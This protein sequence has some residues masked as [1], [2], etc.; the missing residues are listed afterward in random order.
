MAK[1]TTKIAFDMRP[2]GNMN[3]HG[4]LKGR[5]ARFDAHQ[6]RLE[7]KKGHERDTFNGSFQANPSKK[8]V[9]GSAKTWTHS[10]KGHLQ[11]QITNASISAAAVVAA[12]KSKTNKD[13]RLV[14]EKTFAGNDSIMGSRQADKLYGYDGNDTINGG[15]GLAVDKIDGGKGHDAVSFAGISK[16]IVL[17]LTGDKSSVA[18]ANGVASHKIKN[19]EDAIGGKGH[20]AL[21]GDKTANLLSGGKGNDTLIGGGG[22]DTLKGGAGADLLVGGA[23]NDSLEGGGGADTLDGGKGNDTLVGG[24][25][26]DLL[27]GGKGND[28]LD[29]GAGADLLDGGKGKDVMTGG[30]DADTFRFGDVAESGITP[31]TRDV[32]TDFKH[33]LDKIDLSAI[34]AVTSVEDGIDDAFVLDGK[35]TAKTKPAE[36]HIGWYQVDAR[37]TAN[38]RTYIVIN[39]DADKAPEMMIELHGLVKL[40]SVDFIL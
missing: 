32:I 37:G 33:K 30:A 3:L 14:I 11:W 22:N 7:Y 34:D 8:T 16:D 27:L 17:T 25:D 12:A 6:I 29:G 24:R 35:G 26:S 15:G 40:S 19:V 2:T 18:F 23:G 4:L 10:K 5:D 9:S 28:S 1:L 39:T 20:D 13:D 36:G 31:A 38:D 21:T